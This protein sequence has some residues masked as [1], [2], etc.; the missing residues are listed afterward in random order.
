[1]RFVSTRGAAPPLSFSDASLAG[2]APDGGLYVPE[3]WPEIDVDAL[4]PGEPFDRLAARV[5]APFLA[6]DRLEPQIDALCERAFDFP[7]PLVPLGG[8]SAVLELFHGP[9]A[10]FKD[11]GARFLAT[12]FEALL[13]ERAER[14]TI[15]V[16]TSGD[17][18]A[19]VA[20]ACHRRPGMRVAVLFPDGGVAPRQERQLT[21][22]DGNVRS[23][24]VRGTFDDCQ[25]LVKAAFAR[26]G[27]PAEGRLSSANS[28][29]VGRLLPQMAY[30][31]AASL[32]YRA[33]YGRAAGFVVPSGNV[34][35][36]V[37]AF[38]AKRLGFPVREIAL[39]TN[40]NRVLPDWFADGEWNPRPSVKTLANAMDVGN[41]SNMERLL[42]LHPERE[43]MLAIAQSL[44]VDDATIREEIVRGVERWQRVWC[45]HTATAAHFLGRLEGD[46]WVVVSTAHPAK[47]DSIVEPLLGRPVETPARLQALLERPTRC[48]KIEA[49]LDRFLAAMDEEEAR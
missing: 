14:L 18:G 28:I 25:R 43:A 42:H 1:M 37:G 3:S 9:T 26:D 10:A 16:A 8:G 27:W 20:A 11:F 47:F 46:A 33:E 45:P 36:S 40:A 5:I 6:G 30:Y 23:F 49:D 13:A 4:D 22:W 15:L 38:W 39:A 2:L 19:A 41:P 29:N 44:S 17:T 34:G 31:A 21:C 12:C 32:R 35:N 7:M 48:T 24:A